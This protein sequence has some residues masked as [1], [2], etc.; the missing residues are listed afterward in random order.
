METCVLL[1]PFLTH[2]AEPLVSVGDTYVEMRAE[3]GG[4]DDD[5]STG[6]EVVMCAGGGGT[7]L[8]NAATEGLLSVACVLLVARLARMIHSVTTG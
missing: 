8:V 7:A 5:A 6:R 3:K 2:L 1:S 4:G